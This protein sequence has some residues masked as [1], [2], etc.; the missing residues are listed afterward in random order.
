M[1]TRASLTRT[2]ATTASLPIAVGAAI[3]TILAGASAAFAQD[4]GQLAGI[5][6]RQGE[7]YAVSM[8]NGA[9]KAARIDPEPRRNELDFNPNVT[10]VYVLDG[11]A[12]G[13]F[14]VKRDFAGVFAVRLVSTQNGDQKPHRPITVFLRR[15]S[16][17]KRGAV[18]QAMTGEVSAA[19]YYNYHNPHATRASDSY[20]EREFHTDYTYR[21]GEPDRQ[22]YDPRARRSQFHFPEMKAT[23]PTDTAS[24]VI[25]TL[26]GSGEALADVPESRF[27][28]QIKYY[29]RVPNVAAQRRC[30]TVTT[31]LDRTANATLKVT[32]TDLDYPGGLDAF[33]S[34]T[35]WDITWKT[36]IAAS[37]R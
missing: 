21:D 24:Q 18:R 16:V 29:P 5:Q 11:P 25:A 13:L 37:S 23:E 14:S 7:L 30:V 6:Y 28:A 35:T 2:S 34:S 12:D 27:E 4:C 10:L 3:A 22:T 26:F 9:R 20:L 32:M 36:P 33:D 15:D 1:L 8:L 31:K 17:T 19:R